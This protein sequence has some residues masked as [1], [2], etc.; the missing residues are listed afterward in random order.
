MEKIDISSV[1]T[2]GTQW[3][4]WLRMLYTPFSASMAIF[5]F[6]KEV[7]WVEKVLNLPKVKWP[8]LFS[9]LFSF[10]C[11]V[12]SLANSSRFGNGLEKG[13]TNLIADLISDWRAATA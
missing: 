7:C 3:I 5:N 11:I 13:Y 12:I 2:H 4:G 6:K 8:H 1:Y 10:D 9:D